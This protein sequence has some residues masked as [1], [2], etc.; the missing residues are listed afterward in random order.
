M[1]TPTTIGMKIVLH[2]TYEDAIDRT[3]TALKAHGFGVL[4]EIN[5]KDT[6]KAKIDVDF[7]PYIILGAC[8]PHLA[9]RAL[10]ATSEIGLMLPCNVT[11][12]E[13]GEGQMEVA[14]IDPIAMMTVVD[15]P[16]LPAI[17]QEAKTLLSAVLADLN[18]GHS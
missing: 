16:D 3:K 6:L 13:V 1:T 17:A 14:I 8:N 4:T 12:S 5:V 15:H 2:T 11:V 9:H 7:R 18:G 10:T